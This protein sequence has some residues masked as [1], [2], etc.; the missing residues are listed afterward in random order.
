MIKICKDHKISLFTDTQFAGEMDC[1]DGD[2][3]HPLAIGGGYK[4]FEVVQYVI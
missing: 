4:I 1:S 3:Q 2:N